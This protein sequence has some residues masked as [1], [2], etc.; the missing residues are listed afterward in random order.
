MSFIPAMRTFLVNAANR[1]NKTFIISRHNMM[2]NFLRAVNVNP[3]VVVLLQRLGLAFG[4]TMVIAVTDRC[5]C[6]CIHCGVASPDKVNKRALSTDEIIHLIDE[7]KRQGVSVIHLFGG[8]PLLVKDL[9]LIIRHAN[10]RKMP[11]RLDTNGY[12][13]S[14][15]MVKSL[16]EAGLDKISISIDSPDESVHDRYRGVEGIY[17][18]AIDGIALCQKHGLKCCI[19]TYATRDNLRNGELQR[20]IAMA[21]SMNVEVRIVSVVLSGKLREKHEMALT[22]E[23]R[24]ILKGLL[25]KKSVYWE[26]EF[27]D[28]EM[29]PF[30]CVAMAQRAFYVSASGD[31]RPCC[32]LPVNYGNIR[33]ERLEIILKRMWSSEMFIWVRKHKIVDCP[34]NNNDFREKFLGTCE[35]RTAIAGKA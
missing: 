21:K 16:K 4:S 6:K 34:V 12:L 15:D 25:R 14:D 23:D 30:S 2:L 20:L 19:S 17:K 3:A 7:S 11:L 10:A 24:A 1:V 13:L 33:E 5:Q 18:K 22:T 8:E 29:I 9:L 27:I 26:S 31:V 32:F 35:R 28:D